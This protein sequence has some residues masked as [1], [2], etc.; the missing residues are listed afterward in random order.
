M[1]AGKQADRQTYRD[2]DRHRYR[3]DRER[4]AERQI[5]LDRE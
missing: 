3:A 1:Q 4:E 2:G 5:E